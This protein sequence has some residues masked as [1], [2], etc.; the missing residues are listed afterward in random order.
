MKLENK[1][2]WA[3]WGALTS[4]GIT[5]LSVIYL[6]CGVFKKDLP[7]PSLIEQYNNTKQIIANIE[8]NESYLKENA[9]LATNNYFKKS[10]EQQLELDSLTKNKFEKQ[11]LEI[12]KNP[13]YTE[14]CAQ[15]EKEQIKSKKRSN[16]GL[17]AFGLGVGGI[18][19][20]GGNLVLLFKNYDYL[21]KLEETPG[22]VKG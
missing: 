22:A 1:I 8:K 17:W 6:G 5:V 9:Y 16:R 10:Y 11:L 3:G 12:E 13:E 19:V 4:A 20:T 14:Y 7:S 15:L 18:V 2:K 21:K